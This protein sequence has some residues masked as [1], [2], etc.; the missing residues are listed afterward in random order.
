MKK[1]H[2]DICPKCGAQG[3]AVKKCTL[4]SLLKPDAQKHIG[5]GPYRFCASRTCDVV[6]FSLAA[7]SSLF[8]KDSLMVRVG[9]KETSAPRPVCYCFNHSVESIEDEIR[10]TGKST[11]INDITT[12]MKAA[13]WCETKSPMGSC[14]LAVVRGV[15]GETEKR[16]G[17]F[18]TKARDSVEAPRKPSLLWIGTITTAV[19]A[20]ACCWLPLLLIGVGASGAAAL[21]SLET[22][23]P[24][25]VSLTFA[26]LALGFYFAYRP[27][28][29]S[30]A[31]DANGC[32]S[33]P[34]VTPQRFNRAMLWVVAVIAATLLFFPNY[35]GF[36]VN[37]GPTTVITDSQKQIA[38][39]VEGM[40]CEACAAILGKEL[41]K[42]S[43][44]EAVKVNYAKKQA[45]IAYSEMVPN[46]ESL[47]AAVE[48]AGYSGSLKEPAGNIND[49]VDND[50]LDTNEMS[51]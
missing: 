13:C 23:R 40:T 29:C 42:V 45:L 18:P 30:T 34:N 26:L 51:K 32:C 12:Q 14:C 39:S 9:I 4:Q 2:S 22:Y 28:A 27:T 33:P 48:T 44:V 3:K 15:V 11:A 36:F 43:G 17:V 47:L 21:A 1:S 7:T 35:V 20:S 50:R 37:N 19:V 25:F 6:Y 41:R 46:Q 31:A 49:R 38:I 10:S 5:H 8:L 16:L 24:F